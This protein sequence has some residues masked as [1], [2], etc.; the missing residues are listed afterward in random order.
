M[1]EGLVRR[2]P[3]APKIERF[4]GD[5]AHVRIDDSGNHFSTQHPSL[6]V[7]AVNYQHKEGVG[8]HRNDMFVDSVF[9]SPAKIKSSNEFSMAKID[10]E[11]HAIPSETNVTCLI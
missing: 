4:S 3:Y 9:V 2:L 7:C 8:R 6:V 10:H 11:K 5:S 1:P